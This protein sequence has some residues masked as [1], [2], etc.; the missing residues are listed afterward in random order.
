MSKYSIKERAKSVPPEIDLM[1]EKSMEIAN[2]ILNILDLQGKTQ[3][4]LADLLSKKESEISK[5]L[6]GTHNF[7]LLTICKIEAVLGESVLVA[8]P[9]RIITNPIISIDLPRQKPLWSNEQCDSNEF[10]E[11]ED[12]LKLQVDPLHVWTFNLPKSAGC[13]Q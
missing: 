7:T 4:D 6:Q 10:F 11:I 3:K 2:R 8:E 5:W 9:P 13:I 12:H 1:V